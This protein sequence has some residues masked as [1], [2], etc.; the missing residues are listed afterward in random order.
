MSIVSIRSNRPVTLSEEAVEK[1]AELMSGEE[2]GTFLRLSV[3]PGGCA[4]FRYE[5]F[6]DTEEEEGD[7]S[8]TFGAGDGREV[9]VVMDRESAP[10]MVGAQV[11]YEDGLSGQGFKVE[12]PNAA[13][14]CGCGKSFG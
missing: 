9:R 6:F 10:L 11:L 7:T 12:N 4:G 13:H 5:L 1:V 8:T 3:R 2:S 14:S